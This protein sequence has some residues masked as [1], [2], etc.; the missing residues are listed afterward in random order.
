MSHEIRTP[1]NAIIGLTNLALK[2][3]LSARQRD[4]LMKAKGS[5]LSLLAII[6][7]ILDFSKI[8]AGKLSME[9]T[10]FHL[11]DVME[12]LSDTMSN[13]AAGKE[14]ELI[15]VIAPEVPRALVGDPLRLGQVLINLTNNALKFTS[16]GEIVVSVTSRFEDGEAVLSFSVKDTGIGIAP[17]K[18]P[19]LFDP[20]TQLDGSTTRKFGG[21]GLGLTICKQIVGL[22]GGEIYAVSE[23]GRGS[24]F[25]FTARFGLQPEEHQGSPVFPEPLQRL[26]VLV[27]DDNEIARQSFTE[28]LRYY[29]L[30]AKSVSSGMEALDEL[31]HAEESY[32]LVLMDWLMPAMDGIEA[33]RR[34]KSGQLSH[35]PRVVIVTC[36]LEADVHAKAEAAGADAFLTKP[37]SPY[38]L[39]NAIILLFRSEYTKSSSGEV[40]LADQAISSAR[41][42][43]QG[44]RLL[45]V[46]DNAINRQLVTEIL[47]GAGMRVVTAENGR[48]AITVLSRE[49]TTHEAVPIDA[50]LMDIQMPELDGYETAKAIRN[51]QRFARLPIIAMTAHAMQGD[52]EKSLAAGMND[53]INK[54]IDSRLL[55]AMLAQWI[56]P[57]TRR[58]PPPSRVVPD[59]RMD[60]LPE[61]LPGIDIRAAVK[62]LDGNRRLLRKVLQRFQHEFKDEADKIRDALMTGD[63]DSAARLVHTI[64]G[65]A[66]NISATDLQQAAVALE[67][68]INKQGALEGLLGDFQSRLDQVVASSRG[69][70]EPETAEA[71]SSEPMPDMATFKILLSEFDVLLQKS[72]LD[73]EGHFKTIKRFLAGANAPDLRRLEDALDAF[74]FHSARSALAD[75]A[76]QLGITLEGDRP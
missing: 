49:Y 56:Q 39:F 42:A 6:N 71:P 16:S 44:A 14:I 40:F 36:A 23:P 46:E 37:V 10:E 48:E 76:G 35:K 33:T 17:E 22:M 15:I 74:D 65:L 38:Q 60:E 54:P 50:V 70:N 11:D 66:G 4:Y 64:K 28:G 58:T 29:G 73:A 45:L 32:D 72:S 8:E 19:Q 13:L 7:D 1:M 61:A 41:G 2:T 47:E 24:T 59:D 53:H 43:L 3:V 20:F 25:S 57:S 21:T 68:G 34:I 18:I 69:L 52:R 27:V 9:R 26:R 5:S 31:E 63:R 75:I 67:K 55:F 30:N 62:R 12:R 51:D